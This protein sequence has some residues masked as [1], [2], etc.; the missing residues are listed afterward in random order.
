LISLVLYGRNDSHGYNLHRRAALSLN[1]LAEVLTEDG[2]EIVFVDYNTPDELPTFVE[3]LADT[4]TDRCLDLLRVFRVPAALH[5]ERFS[6]LT[7]LPVPEP[8]CRNAAVRRANPANRWLLSTNT[9]MILVPFGD[10]GLSGIC[11]ELPDGFYGLPRFELPEW[12]WE[13]LPRTDPA[14]AL[15]ELSSLGPRLRLD[16][17]TLNDD[18]VRYDAP[19]DFQLCLREDFT[20]IDGFDEEMLHGWH[21]DSNFGRRMVIHRGVE[22]GLEDRV[23]GYHC[24]H[25]RTPTVYGSAAVGNDLARFY[26]SVERAELPAQRTTWGLPDVELEEVQLRSRTGSRFAEAVASV[27]PDGPRE[28]IVSEVRRGRLKLTYDSGH[29]MP[30][31]ADS[32]AVSS[33]GTRIGYLGANAALED[34]LARLVDGLSE[35]DGIALVTA[36]DVSRIDRFD[37]TDVLVVDFG[38]DSSLTPDPSPTH[39]E[40]DDER[41]GFPPVPP[42][43]REVVRAFECLVHRE[44]ARLE[45]GAHPRRFV[46]VNSTAAYADAFVVSNLDCSHTSL[47]SRVRRAT[48]KLVPTSRVCALRDVGWPDRLD[49]RRV[50]LGLRIGEAA[51]IEELDHLDAFGTGWWFPDPGAI[52]TSGARGVVTLACRDAGSAPRVLELSFDR[53]GVHR[54]DA[55]DV[56]ISIEGTM[57]GRRV[58]PGGAGLVTWRVRI[59]AR[60]LSQESFDVVIGLDSQDRWTDDRQLGL[61]L[62]AVAI[63]SGAIPIS[64]MDSVDQA[65]R[66]V[67]RS[68]RARPHRP[69]SGNA[70]SR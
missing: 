21:V 56:R 53:V 44:R 24:N 23:A 6:A 70:Q 20:A 8:V 60:A 30:F 12:L 48:V 40:V 38:L 67:A 31:V 11:R 33:Q 19:G 28:R 5:H 64:L 4:L 59:P 18:W 17:T 14:R 43:L 26:T 47:H 46:L 9:D 55:L 35:D 34:M 68:R 7:H 65:R 61:H 32:I 25:S 42:A 69:H 66:L 3:A 49:R 16:E 1:C 45:H 29:V 13:R 52:W 15:Q 58:L 51:E 36:S 10:A 41:D 39:E 22:G 63:R 54:G 50:P 2:D 57:V 62:R 27:I 37:E